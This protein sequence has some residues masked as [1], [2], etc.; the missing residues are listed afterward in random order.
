VTKHLIVGQHFGL[1]AVFDKS[2]EGV[3]YTLNVDGSVSFW[4]DD[5]VDPEV[6][7]LEGSDELIAKWLTHT[8]NQ[9]LELCIANGWYLCAFF[10]EVKDRDNAYHC[11]VRWENIVEKTA[12]LQEYDAKHGTHYAEFEFYGPLMDLGHAFLHWKKKYL[13]WKEREQA[14]SEAT[15]LM[16]ANAHAALT[17]VEDELCF[18]TIERV[19]SAEGSL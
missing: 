2:P 7:Y 3:V 9:H 15:R 12:R 17:A 1:N 16:E 14:E 19:L 11:L 18:A 5:K 10:A 8:R 13:A 4:T 6:I